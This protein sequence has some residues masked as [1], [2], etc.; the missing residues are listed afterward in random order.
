[1]VTICWRVHSWPPPAAGSPSVSCGSTNI[2]DMFQSKCV[3]SSTVQTDQFPH[4]LIL[5][6]CWKC[7]TSSTQDH[8][9]LEDKIDC[10]S[11]SGAI[12]RMLVSSS[13]VLFQTLSYRNLQQNYFIQVIWKTFRTL[14]ELGHMLALLEFYLMPL[15]AVCLIVELLWCGYRKMMLR[16]VNWCCLTAN[17]T[18]N[19]FMIINEFYCMLSMLEYYFRSLWTCLLI[20]CL[21]D[22]YLLNCWLLYYTG[23]PVGVSVKCRFSKSLF[24]LTPGPSKIPLVPLTYRPPMYPQ[25]YGN[26]LEKC[27]NRENDH[28]DLS[29]LTAMLNANVRDPENVPNCNAFIVLTGLFPQIPVGWRYVLMCWAQCSTYHFPQKCSSWKKNDNFVS[30]STTAI[31]AH[32]GIHDNIRWPEK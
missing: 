10:C 23:Q 5:K 27:L 24:S 26:K 30:M 17:H 19:N 2:S 6:C 8:I 21:I 15:W 1:M 29:P 25:A 20:V 16:K 22:D 3:T 18:M 13:Q 28:F 32:C 7:W 31:I 9:W 12:S 4:L 14:N 11:S